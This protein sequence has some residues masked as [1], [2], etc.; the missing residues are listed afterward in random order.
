M[1]VDMT[2]VQQNKLHSSLLKNKQLNLIFFRV[3]VNIFFEKIIIFLLCFFT[4]ILKA[5]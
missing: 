5:S 3:V 1:S 2:A 4:T